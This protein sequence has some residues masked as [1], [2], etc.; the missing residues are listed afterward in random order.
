MSPSRWA[1]LPYTEKGQKMS[2]AVVVVLVVLIVGVP[3][4]MRLVRALRAVVN[5]SIDEVIN[6]LEKAGQGVQ[7]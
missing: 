6:D 7:K 1:N 3:T 2:N 4:I 5:T